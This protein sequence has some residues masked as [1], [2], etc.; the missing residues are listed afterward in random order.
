MQQEKHRQVEPLL[1][2]QRPRPEPGPVIKKALQAP[3]CPTLALAP[4]GRKRRHRLLLHRWIPEQAHR[5]AFEQQAEAE[6][7]VIGD[8]GLIETIASEDHLAAQQLAVAAQL[9][10]PTGLEP[11]LLDHRIEGHLH[12]LTAGHQV[13]AGIDHRLA[14]LH[15]RPAAGLGKGHQPPEHIDLE[16]RIGIKHH[17]PAAR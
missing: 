5:L 12:G 8:R 6:V 17:Q 16:V 9:D 10:H 13:V 4:Q 7:Q 1:E 14:Q 2:R 3:F 15:R 11:A